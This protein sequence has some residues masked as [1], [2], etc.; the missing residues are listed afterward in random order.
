[1]DRTSGESDAGLPDGTILRLQP[2]L[3]FR[4]QPDHSI[5][6]RGEGAV[7]DFEGDGA[8]ILARCLPALDGSRSL[9]SISVETGVPIDMV[10]AAALALY[11][12]GLVAE[13]SA[14]A[15]DP[16]LFYEH[17]R[18][19]ALFWSQTLLM[20]PTEGP[21]GPGEIHAWL[22]L[23]QLVEHWQYVRTARARLLL[24]ARLADLESVRELWLDL[25][26]QEDAWAAD[27]ESG[28]RSVLGARELA[29]ARAL[30]CTEALCNQMEAVAREHQLGYAVCVAAGFAPEESAAG[31]LTHYQELDGLGVV[32]ATVLRPFLR[33]AERAAELGHSDPIRILFSAQPPLPRAERRTVLNYLAKHVEV[34]GRY[35][36]D[37]V[38]FY[39]THERLNF[40]STR[41]AVGSDLTARRPLRKVTDLW[42]VLRAY[43]RGS[44]HLSSRGPA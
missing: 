16:L 18:A 12:S 15:I 20:A 32:P 30:P 41:R 38:D 21:G 17:A 11:S 23:G 24:A 36:R 1:M 42:N 33:Y 27:L 4:L 44:S 2:G 39:T 37:V 31:L 25:A 19:A 26:K 13:D 10:R 28:L 29:H 43:P 22:A 14:D 3:A 5:A 35:H 40:V 7:Y 6:L 9:T 34:L 8:A